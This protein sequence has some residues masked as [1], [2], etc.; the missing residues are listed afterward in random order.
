[1]EYLKYIFKK[2]IKKIKK[3]LTTALKSLDSFIHWGNGLNVEY[4]LIAPDKNWQITG[5]PLN[6]TL[7]YDALVLPKIFCVHSVASYFRVHSAR[8]EHFGQ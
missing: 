5:S 2:K 7:H 4:F 3:I 8:Y 6:P 1:M